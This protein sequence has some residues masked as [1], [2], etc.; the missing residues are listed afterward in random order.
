MILQRWFA[1]TPL[2]PDPILIGGT[3]GSG[4]RVVQS[5]VESA[6][7]FMGHN[8]NESKDALDFEPLL[9]RLVNQVLQETRGLNYLPSDLSPAL[10]ESALRELHDC[11]EAFLRRRPRHATR[12]GIK[13]P[14]LMYLL[15]LFQ[16]L[17]PELQFIHVVRDGRDM[18]FSENQNQLRKHYAAM[19]GEDVSGDL[20]SASLRLWAKA[21]GDVH[22]FGERML[23]ERYHTLRFEDLCADPVGVTARLLRFCVLAPLPDR[24]VRK[25]V[26]TPDSLG[27]WQQQDGA[28]GGA[29]GVQEAATLSLWGYGA[30]CTEGTEGKP[31]GREQEASQK[32]S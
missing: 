32:A 21:N 15:P 29:F 2:T 27:R 13:T 9:D 19:F 28:L 7:V 1:R 31:F 4:T 14:R 22:A 3:G 23:P 20:P 11:C 17:Y 30:C 10:R 12:W 24:H 16:A 5:L 25:Q 26:R 8:L 6:G 18:A